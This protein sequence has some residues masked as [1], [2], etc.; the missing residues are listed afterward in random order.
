MLSLTSFLILAGLL[1][2]G[3]GIQHTRDKTITCLWVL[4][5]AATVLLVLSLL[6]PP[7]NFAFRPIS[8]LR[9]TILAV[10]AVAPTTPGLINV[11]CSSSVLH[12]LLL[13]SFLVVL[14]RL[15]SL[16]STDPLILASLP[17]FQPPERWVTLSNIKLLRSNLI[18]VYAV[19][20]VQSGSGQGCFP[21]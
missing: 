13:L 5:S 4:G 17:R 9:T 12:P 7:R 3:R 1:H 20:W 15:L 21:H 2:H 14:F 18:N 6:I 11:G 8:R 16:R 19:I 10:T